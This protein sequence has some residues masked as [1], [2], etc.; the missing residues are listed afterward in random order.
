ML[1]ARSA[2]LAVKARARLSAYTAAVTDFEVFDVLADFDCYAG[3]FVADAAWVER[4]ALKLTINV[5]IL[6]SGIRAKESL[7]H[8]DLNVCKSEPQIPQCVILISTSSSVHVFGSNS[9]HFISPLA[10][11]L[12]KAI[13]PWNL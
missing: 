6:E 2:F 8:P 9:C 5:R 12:S 7:T 3:D 13:H 10:A 11:F 1:E 4:G